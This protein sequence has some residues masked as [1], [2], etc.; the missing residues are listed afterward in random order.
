MTFI[1]VFY[2]R[3]IDKVKKTLLIALAVI[4]S[5]AFTTAN[6]A[7][8]NKKD[9]K[10]AAKVE[11]VSL[12]T[13]SDTLSYAAGMARTEGLLPYL[14][15]SFGIEDKDMAD[16]IRGFEDALKQGVTSNM[17]A[18]GTGMQIAYMV[19]NRMIP[20]L[21]EEFKSSNDSIST[22]LF[23]QGFLASLKK[24]NSVLAD[25]VAKPYFNNAVKSNIDRINMKN[26]KEGEDFLAANAKKEG[27]VTLPDG[28]QYKVLTQGTG[29]KPKATDRVVVKYEGKTLDG[30]VFDS[31]YKRNP[32]TTTFGVSQV[33]K[34]WTEAL[35]L[36]PVG[37]KWEVYIPYNLAYGERGA[38]RDIKPYDALIFTVEL[39]DIEKPKTKNEVKVVNKEKA[40]KTAVIKKVAK[41]NKK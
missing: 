5:G 3:N 32:Q 39:V 18:Y 29:E 40:S 4:A 16:F 27:V 22:K 37:S 26:K 12:S 1:N 28:L 25:S 13:T 36:M 24:D 9:K 38:G 21:K 31:S 2:N 20:Y 30:K 10:E 15:Q 8:K 23:N 7:K 34:G 17:N 33:I 11:A 41:G 6:A 14:K 35:Q 19:D